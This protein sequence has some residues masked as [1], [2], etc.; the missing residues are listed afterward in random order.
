MDAGD[1]T[2]SC[3]LCKTRLGTADLIVE[4]QL[5]MSH[6]CFAD[7]ENVYFDYSTKLIIKESSVNRETEENSPILQGTLNTPAAFSE[8]KEK[9]TD[10]MVKLLISAYKEKFSSSA[11]TKKKVWE[12]ISAKMGEFGY[13]KDG[14]KCDEKWRNLKKSYDKVK[15]ELNKSG[16]KNISWAFYKD[17]EEIF[18]RDPH[19]EPV[20]TCS[21]SGVTTIRCISNEMEK[22]LSP[23][24][25][26]NSFSSE[27]VTPKKKQRKYSPYQT[28]QGRERRHKEKMDLKKE[29]F[30]WFKENYKKKE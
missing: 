12:L 21:S 15:Q 25:S 7:V 23:G 8:T 16:N 2:F 9:W 5:L 18:C 10:N 24:C 11:Y 27:A 29:M 28:E 6:S 19:F 13:K 14:L 30:T 20:S 26:Q 4:E 17:M 22:N 3:G 1:E